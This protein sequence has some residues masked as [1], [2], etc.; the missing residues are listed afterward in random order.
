[1]K[2][3]IEGLRSRLH[4]MLLPV[5]SRFLKKQLKNTDFSIIASNCV[6][7]RMYLETG[8][9]Y[10][11]PFV[12]LYIFAPDYIKLLKSLKH[13]LSQPLEF[14]DKSKYQNQCMPA[15][16]GHSYPIGL[17]G[18]EIELHF[19]H[20]K[21]EAD[22]LIKWNRRLKRINWDNLF[23]TCTDRDL[24]TDELLKEYNSL[25]FEHKVCFTAKNNPGIN[26]SVWIREDQN[27]TSIRDLFTDYRTLKKNFDYVKW[28]N[29][30][31]S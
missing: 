21:S 24:F 31:K 4:S 7:T 8:I 30:V 27:Q 28:L 6:G 2:R 13:Y 29:S 22:A 1:M 23:I 10:T 12:G 15:K 19:L 18:G 16:N 26:S 9:P 20:Y 3:I 11:S 25:P 14:T 5:R 17:L